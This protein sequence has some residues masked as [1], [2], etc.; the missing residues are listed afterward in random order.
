MN[1][2]VTMTNDLKRYYRGYNSFHVPKNIRSLSNRRIEILDKVLTVNDIELFIDTFETD[3][4]RVPLGKSEVI[5]DVHRGKIRC[6]NKRAWQYMVTGKEPPN[7]P[8][9]LTLG[10]IIHSWKVGHG[11]CNAELYRLL[12]SYMHLFDQLT[13]TLPDHS[14]FACAYKVVGGYKKLYVQDPIHRRTWVI[15]LVHSA[16]RAYDR[17][18]SWPLA[19]EIS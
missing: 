10:P 6:Q 14:G 5:F 18:F 12:E 17:N 1:Q 9:G 4:V 16:R 8:L 13:D 19:K 11:S 2:Q 3:V 15:E 7:C